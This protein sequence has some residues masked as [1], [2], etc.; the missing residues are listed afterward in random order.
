VPM[1][2]AVQQ[3]QL[4]GKI[5]AFQPQHALEKLMV[6]KSHVL[7]HLH[8]AIQPKQLQVVLLVNSAPLH[9]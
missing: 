6:F 4:T 7:Q 5:C 2:I 8:H 3:D 9:H 1:E